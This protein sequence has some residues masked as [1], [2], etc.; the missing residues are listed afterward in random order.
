[1]KKI[2]L[3]MV[4]ALFGAMAAFAQEW[5]DMSRPPPS[6][7]PYGQPPGSL[8]YGPPIYVGP[9]PD[10]PYPEPRPEG[11]LYEVVDGKTVLIIKYIGNA[12]T[13]TIPG[14]INNLPVTS[15][16]NEAFTV[17]I[18][19]SGTTA[20][21]PEYSSSLTSITIPSSVTYIEDDA[22]V[23]CNSLTSIIVENNNSS[24]ASIDGVLFDRNIR[25]LIK[26]PQVKN[27]KAYIIPSSVT[28]ISDYAFEGCW[29]LYSV[30]MPPSLKSIGYG[31][32]SLSG[33][34]SANIPS[35]VTSIG[36]YAFNKCE[37]LTSVNIP[38]S[39]KSIGNGMFQFCDSL[40]SIVIPS[41]V[42]SIGS[43][44]FGYCN[45]LTSVTIPSSVTLIGEYAFFRCRSLTS[46]TLS[47]RTQV[48]ESAFPDNARIIYR[49]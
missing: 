37:S 27:Q 7:P 28:S 3:I 15:I 40:T 45:S 23:G 11:L 5:Y 6:P 1:M 18:D 42:T 26:Y 35:S 2:V 24:Y 43:G 16:G 33:L 36:D 34:T 41:S 8:S 25:T 48:G 21:Y 4:L 38:S 31:A 9:P 39:L 46:I 44:A 20:M 47:R 13:L 10:S 17:R 30:T 32:F 22:F 29:S 14:Y 19:M 12:T 49:D